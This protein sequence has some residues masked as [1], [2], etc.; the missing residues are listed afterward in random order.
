[1]INT[2]KILQE[3]QGKPGLIYTNI[4]IEKLSE[5]KEKVKIFYPR[6]ETDKKKQ[7]KLISDIE[8]LQKLIK[9]Y[10]DEIESITMTE[11]PEISKDQL[12]DLQ[13]SFKQ[14]RNTEKQIDE[15]FYKLTDKYE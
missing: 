5:L 14:I 10:F 7:T 1:M 11:N 12:S 8:N 13:N 15:R 4:E 3:I 6:N 2:Q 9:N